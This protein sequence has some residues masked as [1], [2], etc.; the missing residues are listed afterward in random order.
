MKQTGYFIQKIRFIIQIQKRFSSKHPDK[1]EFSSQ[2]YYHDVS[3]L[4]VKLN[5]LVST[6]SFLYKKSIFNLANRVATVS[7][8]NIRSLSLLFVPRYYEIL[9]NLVT[10]FFSQDSN[11]SGFQWDSCYSIFS[12]MCMFCRSL[13]VF[14][15][16]FFWPVYCLSFFDLRVLI[17]PLVS[18]NSSLLTSGSE[19]L[20]YVDPLQLFYF[21]VRFIKIKTTSR[22]CVLTKQHPAPK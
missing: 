21:V 19:P 20:S 14:L 12:F 15:Y 10:N 13:F 1:S 2:M 16:I 6:A 4:N 3:K 18:S 11:T 9:T 5:L 17:T 7:H 22:L 8:R